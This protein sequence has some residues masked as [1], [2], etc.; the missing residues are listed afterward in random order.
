MSPNEAIERQ[1]FSMR[2]ARR[3]AEVTTCILGQN[4]RQCLSVSD[5]PQYGQVGLLLRKANLYPTCKFR[6]WILIRTSHGRLGTA[7][8]SRVATTLFQLMWFPHLTPRFCCLY[9]WLRLSH[10]QLTGSIPAMLRA[11]QK[12]E[13]LFMDNNSLTGPLPEFDSTG[14]LNH[15]ILSNNQLSRRIPISVTTLS[16]LQT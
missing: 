14:T 1:G 11:L 6:P 8:E 2:R 5:S 12:L 13:S 7:N 9:D 10:N 4:R 16:T 15:V 3:R